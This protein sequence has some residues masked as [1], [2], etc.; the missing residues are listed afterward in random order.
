MLNTKT[1]MTNNMETRQIIISGKVQAVGFRNW[2]KKTCENLSLE[3]NVRNTVDMKVEAM[4]TGH[5]FNLDRFCWLCRRGPL[6][7]KV[8]DVKIKCVDLKEFGSFNII[9]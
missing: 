3:G 8:E 7:A 2:V 9:Y 4:I 5:K 1:L 6:L